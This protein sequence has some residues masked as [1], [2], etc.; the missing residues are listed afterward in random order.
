MG[1]D[2]MAKAIPFLSYEDKINL[3]EILVDSIKGSV[4]KNT[5]QSQG[6]TD[7]TDT[8][9]KGYFDLFGSDPSFPEEQQEKRQNVME[10]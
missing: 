6:K 1:Y 7:F 10:L 2:T 8:Y 5:E 9:P 3:L 4:L